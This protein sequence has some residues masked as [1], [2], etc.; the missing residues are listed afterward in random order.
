[1]TGGRRRHWEAGYDCEAGGEGFA[2]GV[3]GG[4]RGGNG[5][6][7]GERGGGTAAV[8]SEFLAAHLTY[9]SI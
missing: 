9:L 2:E 4:M 8:L 5:G 7:D 3:Y 6:G 1:M